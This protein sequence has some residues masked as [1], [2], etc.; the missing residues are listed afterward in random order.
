MKSH[1]T[2]INC[3]IVRQKQDFIQ[4]SFSYRPYPPSYLSPSTPYHPFPTLPSYP[5]P[6]TPSHPFPLLEYNNPYSLLFS[7]NLKIS[8]LFFIYTIPSQ[9][10]LPVLT[11]LF[12]SIGFPRSHFRTKLLLR[13]GGE[14]RTGILP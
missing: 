4:E 14:H 9:P 8:F 5:S 11:L 13:V 1:N 6:S 3:I 7:C 12:A 10:I 2:R